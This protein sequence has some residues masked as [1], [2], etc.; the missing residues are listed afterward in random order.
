MCLCLYVTVILKEK[1]V[2][3]LIIGKKE[4]IGGRGIEKLEEENGRGK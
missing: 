4:A 1:E 3:F 2:I